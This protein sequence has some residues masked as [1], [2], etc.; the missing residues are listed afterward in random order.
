[1][2]T[3]KQVPAQTEQKPQH[4]E[5]LIAAGINEAEVEKLK[6][7]GYSFVYLYETNGLVLDQWQQAYCGARHGSVEK[8]EHDLNEAIRAGRARKVVKI[9]L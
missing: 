5:R 9:G 7:D 2:A 6:R 3:R 1:M 8:V 4:D